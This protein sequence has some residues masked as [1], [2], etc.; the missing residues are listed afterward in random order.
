MLRFLERHRAYDVTEGAEDDT[1]RMVELN[2]LHDACEAMRLFDRE[3]AETDSGIEGT[4]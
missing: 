2:K 3:A 1:A 4:G